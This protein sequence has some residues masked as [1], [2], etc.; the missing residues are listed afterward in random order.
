MREKKLRSKTRPFFGLITCVLLALGGIFCLVNPLQAAYGDTSTFLGQLYTGDGGPAIDAYLDMPYGFTHDGQGNIYIA[1]TYNNVIRKID[2]SN[3]ISTYSGTGEFGR[4]DGFR[5]LA[6]WGYPK[7]ISYNASDG[8]FYVADTGNSRIRKIDSSNNVSTITTTDSTSFLVPQEIVASGSYLYIADTGNNRVVKMSTSG[9][10]LTVLA[11]SLNSPAK[12]VLNGDYLYIVD[13]GSESIIKVNINSGS[14]STLASD[15]TEPQAITYYNGTLYVAAG[16]NGVWNEIWTVN[17]DNGEK[18]MIQ[19]RRETEWLNKGTDMFVREDSGVPRIYILQGGGSSLF[20]FDINGDD[21]QQIAGRHRYGDEEGHAGEALVGHPQALAFSPDERRL[22]IAFA[23][24][25]K[26]AE[27]DLWTDQL[28]HIAGHLMDNYVE[29]TGGAA[30]FSDVVDMK[31]SS[32]GFTL[33]LVD[34]NSNRIRKLDVATKTTSYITGAGEFNSDGE[35]DNGYQEGGPCSDRFDA[36]VGGCAYFNRPTG[37][38]LTSDESVL[39]IADTGNNR[40]RKVVISTGQTSLIAGSGSSGFTDGAGTS[41]TFNG[42]YTLALSADNRTLY[43]ADKYNHAIR[44]INL[45]NNTVS[46]LVGT[47]NIGYREGSFSDAVLA[48][49]EYIELGPDNNLYVSEAGS[50]RVRKLDLTN[51]ETSLVSGSG[52]RGHINGAKEVAEWD[53]PKGMAFLNTHLYIS[54]FRNDLVRVID[55]DTSIPSDRDIVQPGKSFMAYA[56]HL[57]GG[58]NVAVGNVTGDEAKEIITGTGE[59]FGPQIRIFNQDGEA[60]GSFF[61]YSE[62]LRAGVRLTTGDLDGDGY[63][64]IISVPGPG[65]VP[66]IRIFDGSGNIDVNTGFYAL[67]GKFKG[68]AYVASADV[69]GSGRADIIVAAGQGGG[70]QVTVHEPGGSVIANFFAYDK[71]TFRYGIT[72]ATLDTDGNGKYEIITGPEYG[73]PHVQFFTL[74]P[75]EVKQLNPGFY[76]FDEDYKGGVH[77]AGGDYDG[78][79]GDEIIVGSGIGMDS[80]VRIFNQRLFTP[81]EEIRP[82]AQGVT[83]GVIVA[84]GDVDKDGKDEIVTMPRSN[85]GPNFRILEE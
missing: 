31:M 39:Y 51:E 77:V 73:S 7:G 15:F 57:R 27:Y 45:T 11:S 80:T 10:A 50:L 79:G 16:E 72:V 46:T 68:G 24:G 56:P 1:D 61:A 65:A 84:A 35:S 14:K 76:A 33:Y 48:I 28:K 44:A 52:G 67:D 22:Y 4:Q 54:D 12:L 81:I 3:N 74:L 38:A 64:E 41:A 17:P 55:M 82:Y 85:G 49:P 37:I 26:I 69:N 71:N 83:G 21:M 13:L 42:P 18:N 58:W 43:V 25:N 62:T 70:P 34:R 60:L 59:G 63:D 47:G 30:R 29:E 32:D 78:D 53:A 5:P 40:I 66:H 20:S 23:Q 8:Y 36:G 19:K 6:T 9:G 2:S 75:N